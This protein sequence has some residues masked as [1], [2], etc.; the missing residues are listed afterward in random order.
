MNPFILHSESAC[1][2]SALGFTPVPWSVPTIG[3]G[4]SKKGK[5][6]RFTT[7]PKK[8]KTSASGRMTL[9]LKDW[10]KVVKE[11]GQAA[12]GG[13]DPITEQVRLEFL[14]LFKA[15]KK[16]LIGTIP[17]TPVEWVEGE[18]VKHT[19]MA[20]LTN[21]VKAAED[22][23]EGTVYAND[24]QVRE[25]NGLAIYAAVPGV[26]V[27]VSRITGVSMVPECETSLNTNTLFA[28]PSKAQARRSTRTTRPTPPPPI[29]SGPSGP[30]SSSAS[31]GS[32]PA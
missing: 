8:T 31:S 32:S 10:Q 6:F 16:A 1:E 30:S 23:L 9:S 5:K 2:F 3:T 22:A 24:V 28:T 11:A 15:P 7:R 25:S 18:S 17:P 27:R 12:M 29:A 4:Y 20:D 19:N 26:W 14:F 13:A 21:L